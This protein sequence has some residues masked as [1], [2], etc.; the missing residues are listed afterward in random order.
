M[1]STLTPDAT[2]HRLYVVCPRTP[3]VTADESADR[4]ARQSVPTLEPNANLAR[5][6]AWLDV[7]HSR[8]TADWAVLDVRLYGATAGVYVNLFCFTAER[9]YRWRRGLT[10]SP[11]FSLHL[12]ATAT[13]TS[14]AGASGTAKVRRRAPSTVKAETS[15]FDK[16]ANGV[17][18]SVVFVFC[19]TIVQVPCTKP[20]T[21]KV[22]LPMGGVARPFTLKM[23]VRSACARSALS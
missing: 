3:N 13:R 1:G 20:S 11:S 10:R 2:Q 23:R 17:N 19:R 8:A 22:G 18:V 12:E 16:R 9:A 7:N 4:A 6:V 15:F 14:C 5:L 21:R